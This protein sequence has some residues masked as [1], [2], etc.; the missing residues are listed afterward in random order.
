[1]YPYEPNPN[2]VNY[3]KYGNSRETLFEAMCQG[4]ADHIMTDETF[5]FVIPTG[6]AM[7]NAWSSYLTEKDLHRDYG[8]A[9]DMA[10]A[11]TAYVWY[12]KLMGIEQLEEIQLDV[13]PK[14]F[15]KST[16]DKTQGRVLTEAEKAIMLESINNALKNPLE[17]TQ[18]QY[19]EKP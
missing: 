6:T 11:M 13:I 19:T 1:M 5:R 18:S 9:T 4:V 15:L 2:K 7:Q 12:C 3:Q 8:H 14:A 16:A 17:M 10:R